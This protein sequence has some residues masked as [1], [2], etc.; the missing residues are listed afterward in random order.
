[1]N[2]SKFNLKN[3]F[4]FLIIFVTISQIV[5]FYSFYEEYS[6]W[7]Y[8]DWII[9][10][11]GG[12]IRRGFIGEILYNI[13]YLFGVD[14]DFLVLIFVNLLFLSCSIFLFKSLEII[15]KNQ[16]NILIFLSPGFFLYPLMNSEIIGRKDILMI[17]SMSL[18]VFFENKLKNFFLL[19]LIIFLIIFTSL[20][21]SAFLFYSPYI[22]IVYYF[23]LLRRESNLILFYLIAAI[24]TI[25][26]CFILIFLNQGN[27]NQVNEICESIKDFITES[28]S[29]YGQISWL[30]NNSKV[31]LVEKFSLKQGFFKIFL[32]YFLSFFLVNIFLAIKLFKSNFNF[33]NKSLNN[34]NPLT[35]FL[36]LFVLTFPV[37]ILGLDWGRYIHISYSCSFFILYYLLNN[38]LIISN[39]SLK[40]KN[41]LLV[42]IIFFYS[43]MWTFPFYNAENFKFT[44][45]KPIYKI[46]NLD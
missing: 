28:C 16:L 22:I 45:K 17:F 3:F 44:L 20:S 24:S 29:S 18:I 46:L 6:A 15:K 37:Y 35:P 41:S 21:H 19:F 39:Y 7:Q 13:Y 31:Y 34:V 32:V 1:M 42:L 8:A 4:L 2:S 12:F 9:N 38:E 26:F 36:I 14:L 40:I 23:I 30:A 27:L 10:Y 5:K 25:I 43:F 11:Q 33:S